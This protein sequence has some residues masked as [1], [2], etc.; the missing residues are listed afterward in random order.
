MVRTQPLMV[1]AIVA[2][3]LAPTASAN[4]VLNGGFEAPVVTPNTFDEVN[5]GESDLAPWVVTKTAV[6]VVHQGFLGP[7][8]EGLQYLDLDGTPGPGGIY[9]DLATIPGV[10]YFLTFDYANHPQSN[11][12][13]YEATVDVLDG[14]C[15][16]FGRA[17]DAYPHSRPPL[18]LWIGRRLQRSFVAGGEITRLTFDSTAIGDDYGGILLD[19]ISVAIPEASSVLCCGLI[20]GIVGVGAAMRRWWARTKS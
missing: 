5:A 16:S 14:S 6:D 12:A 8:A 18:E 9:Q 15:E 7:A 20:A 1:L 4:I 17:G 10:T 11:L 2:V 13:P 3:A 19:N